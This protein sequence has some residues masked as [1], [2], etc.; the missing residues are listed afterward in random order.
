[1]INKNA[2]INAYIYCYGGTKT[3]AARVYK[4]TGAGYH[5]AVI[6]SA[7]QD[8]KKAFISD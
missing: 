7:K 2:F 6:E 3:A 5:A 1:M 8:A 4:N